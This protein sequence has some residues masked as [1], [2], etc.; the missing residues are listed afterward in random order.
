[1]RAEIGLARRAA[2]VVS[3]LV[4]LFSIAGLAGCGQS[5][6]EM[7]KVTGRVLLDGTGVTAGSVFFHPAADNAFQDDVPSGQLQLD[8]T[9]TVKTFPFGEG[10]PRGKYKVT[11]SPELAN[12]LKQPDY[13][14]KQ[15]TPWE[16]DVADSPI[17]G[18]ELELPSSQDP[19]PAGSQS[20]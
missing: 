9:F 16:V 18:L 13:A 3:A 15:L 6:P 20:K 19:S 8:G 10:V 14:S 4:L 5:G 17:A 11:L 7:V 2:A 1:M 12:Q